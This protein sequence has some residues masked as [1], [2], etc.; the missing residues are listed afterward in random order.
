[1]LA[2]VYRIALVIA[3]EEFFACVQIFGRELP[4][5]KYCQKKWPDER[6]NRVVA[7]ILRKRGLN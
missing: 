3:L 2:T 1:M 6:I 4:L 7:N 5:A